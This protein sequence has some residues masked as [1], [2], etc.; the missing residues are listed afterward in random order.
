MFTYQQI[1]NTPAI[2]SSYKSREHVPMECNQCQTKH[3]RP[4]HDIQIALRQNIKNNFCSRKCQETFKKEN[5]VDI[6]INV[7]CAKCNNVFARTPSHIRTGNNFCS[8]SCSN[9]FR[10]KKNNIPINHCKN[11][12]K[13][14]NKKRKT[15]VYCSNTCQF[16]WQFI[17]ETIPKVE[18][19]EV[20][21][22]STLKKYL[23]HIRSY[24]CVRVKIVVLA[25]G[26][27]NPFPFTVIT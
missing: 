2:L 7:T 22:T 3:L 6:R 5:T 10:S 8:T 25:S 16:E 21:D 1:I 13:K 19:G 4:K 20:Y 18:R 11:C 17:N 27:E 14:F 12:N 26:R 9:K 15:N 23:T 24:V